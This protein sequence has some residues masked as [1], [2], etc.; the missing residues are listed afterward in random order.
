MRRG[1]AALVVA[2][3]LTPGTFAGADDAAPTIRITSPLGRTGL[4]GTIRVVARLEGL[5]ERD[6]VPVQFYV[7]NLFLASD[8][9]G[10]PYDALWTDDNPFEKRE[11]KVEAELPSGRTLRDTIILKPL[12]VTEAIEVASVAVEATVVD[13]KGRF[14]KGLT[15]KDFDLRE[16][17]QSQDLD[18]VSQSRE[19]ALFALLVDGSQSMAI[20]SEAVRAA[21]A[22]L[23]APLG[24]DDQILVAPFSRT[25]SSVT[26]PT[27]D[28][29]T[30]LDAIG[31]IRH[32]GG[33]AILDAV[34]QAAGVVAG[35]TRRKA[36]VLITDGYDENSE[37]GFDE[38]V[39]KL[40]QGGVTL[41]VIGFGGVAGISLKGEKLLG[42][43]AEE[44]GGHAW[45]PRDERQLTSA[46]ETI[47]T[48]VQHRYLLTYTPRNQSQDGNWRAIEVAVP[49]TE[50]R[51]RT[52][53]GYTA[54]IAPPVRAS[55][56][57]TG[58]GAGQVPLSLIREDLVILEDGVPQSVDVFQEAVLPVTFML[59]L[60]AS[61]SMKRSAAAAG[62]RSRVYRCHAPG[63]S[64][65][66][67]PLCVQVE[68]HPLSDRTAGLVTQGH[69]RVR[70][71]RRNGF[72]RCPLRLAGAA[73]FGPGPA[74]RGRRD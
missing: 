69:R 61:G 13:P 32:S 44:T 17:A 60:D 52:R 22:R 64:G 66:D 7:D 40:R 25:I 46:Y 38:A 70:R 36:I 35:A 11:L 19:P 41:Y 21:A 3:A 57:F 5:V 26:G 45:F 73:V 1:V 47:A 27:T 62:G 12:E 58:V 15:A 51:V 29:A 65:R 53:K 34:G 8:T 9:D 63:R 2:T 71:R 59:A 6:P 72:V 33:T 16:D 23:L 54:P 30:V 68:L 42:Q 50:F 10:P 74:R 55:I 49:G 37:S 20:R 4:P 56:E 14:I 48:D 28:R 39:E 24:A 43:L 67:D 31:A 18:L